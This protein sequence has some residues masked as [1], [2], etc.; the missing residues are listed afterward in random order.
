MQK[1]HKKPDNFQMIAKTISG[2]EKV[3]ADELSALGAVDVQTLNRAVGFKGDT[4]F[5][6]KANLWC[7]TA[8]RI[9]KPIK[10]F[11]VNSNEDLYNGIFSIEWEE[12][13]DTDQ[14]LAVDAVVNDSFFNHSQFVA[15][16]T[17][18][19]VVDRFREKFGKR[20]SVNIEHPDLLINIHIYKETCSVSLDSSGDSLHKRGYRKRAVEAPLSEVLAAGLI[21]LSGW[22]KQS[23]F[24]DPMCGS[25]TILIE[26][27]LIANNIPPGYYKKDFG[28]QHW[29]EYDDSLWKTISHAA[30]SRQ[31]E[32]DF[33][34]VGSDISSY[35][36]DTAEENI[37]FARLHKDISL[38][39][40]AFENSSGPEGGGILITNPPYGERLKE[41]DI[42]EFYKNIG[43]T[44][45]K[46]YKGYD[47]WIISSDVT[48]LKS[49][50]LH[51][52]RNISIFNGPLECKFCRFSIYEGSKKIK[53]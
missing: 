49:I 50:G 38:K 19:A 42:I 35:S 22:D 31:T 5:M 44:L 12:F 46:N 33:E 34:I 20:P 4:G 10:S 14:T 13:I 53:Q 18:D 32:F 40:E 9:L 2:L 28:F 48:A 27:A 51:A 52:T 21:L 39:V 23:N 17:K 8:L 6:Y 16:K 3:L 29:K 47:A 25:G 41:N 15:Q 45:K 30:L 26:A 7:R 24:V 1:V 36:I 37:K 11:S 43:H